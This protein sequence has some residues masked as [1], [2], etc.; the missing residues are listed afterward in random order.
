LSR[1]LA[2][3]LDRDARARPEIWLLLLFASWEILNE[4]AIG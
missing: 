1:G 4:V 3:D 2:I